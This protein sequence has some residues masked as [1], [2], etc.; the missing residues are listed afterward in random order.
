MTLARTTT[1][2][3]RKPPKSELNPTPDDFE[4]AADLVRGYQDQALSMFD[5]VTAVVGR[6]LRM[7]VWA[8]D[9]HFDIVRAEVW[10]D[11]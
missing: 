2:A 11:A 1:D 3:S 6:R 9:H 5:A 10:R 8:Y 7:P 4:Q